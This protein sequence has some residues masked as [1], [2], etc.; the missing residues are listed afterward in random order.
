MKKNKIWILSLLI[1][2]A[3]FVLAGCDKGTV[4]A[5]LDISTEDGAGEYAMDLFIRSDDDTSSQLANGIDG[6]VKSIQ[7]YGDEKGVA[8]EL[9]TRHETVQK[10]DDN[11]EDGTPED[12]EADVINVKFSFDSREDLNAKMVT[13]SNGGDVAT[14]KGFVNFITNPDGTTTVSYWNK[15]IEE[16]VLAMATHIHDDKDAYSGSEAPDE[17]ATTD[18]LEITVDG[19]AQEM[20]LSAYS[21]FPNRHFEV[22]G[23]YVDESKIATPTP[24]VEPAQDEENTSD[25]ASE[26]ADTAADSSKEP[27]E[28]NSTAIIIAV[29]AVVVVI[30]VGAAFVV[31]R[32]RKNSSK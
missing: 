12:H 21:A 23:T 8:L 31:S 32:K 26:S 28:S 7:A 19:K 9:A 5:Y 1:V 29:V 17:L 24:T 18:F 20:I 30:A 14:K 25:G 11:D 22:A 13:L 16:V 2:L 3:C 15:A 10:W 27:A 6:V 4:T